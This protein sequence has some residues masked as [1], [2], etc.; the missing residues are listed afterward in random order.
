[1]DIDTFLRLA[2]Q[3]NNLGWAVQDQLRKLVD[4]EDP[5]ALNANAVAMCVKFLRMLDKAAVDGAQD[6]LDPL[7]AA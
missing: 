4:G 6:I 7:E 3:Y 5:K 1:M 2:E